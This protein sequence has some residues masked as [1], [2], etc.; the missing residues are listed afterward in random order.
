MGSQSTPPLIITRDEAAQL[1]G[2]RG[3]TCAFD[4]FAR[5]MGFKKVPHRRGCFYRDQI[6]AVLDDEM[7]LAHDAHDP[8]GDEWIRKN[9]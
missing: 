6:K 5:K 8:A 4:Q 9:A 2:Y 3:A 1:C 7:G